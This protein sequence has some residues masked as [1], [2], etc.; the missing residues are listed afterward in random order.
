MILFPRRWMDGWMTSILQQWED[1]LFDVLFFGWCFGI[2]AV[3]GLIC[4]H[5][6]LHIQ[7]WSM[8]WIRFL[9][10]S[11]G[12]LRNLINKSKEYQKPSIKT[13]PLKDMLKKMALYVNWIKYNWLFDKPLQCYLHVGFLHV[14]IKEYGHHMKWNFEDSTLITVYDWF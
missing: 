1:F 2:V 9:V 7:F 14:H 3:C 12:L 13:T 11:F 5:L 10:D 6:Q 4:G 8:D